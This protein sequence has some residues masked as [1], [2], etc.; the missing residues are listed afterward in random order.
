M[1]LAIYSFTHVP[2]GEMAAARLAALSIA[3]ALCALI[4]NQ[5]LTRRAERLLGFDDS[6]NAYARR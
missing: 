3:L 2:D 6:H 1:P 5:V 4:A